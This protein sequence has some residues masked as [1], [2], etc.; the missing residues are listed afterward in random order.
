M[1]ISL[2][3]LIDKDGRVIYSGSYDDCYKINFNG[4]IKDLKIIQLKGEY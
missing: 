2:Y 3:V 4:M 1:I